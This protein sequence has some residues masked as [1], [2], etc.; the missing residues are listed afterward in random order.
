MPAEAHVGHS[1]TNV[2]SASTTCAAPAGAFGARDVA[3]DAA[4]PAHEVVVRL[5]RPSLEERGVTGKVYARGEAGTGEGVEAVVDRLGRD[6]AETVPHPSPDLVRAEVLMVAGR[7]RQDVEHGGPLRRRTQPRSAEQVEG[8]RHPSITTPQQ[9]TGNR[10][11]PPLAPS[12]R[13]LGRRGRAALP[14]RAQS[15]APG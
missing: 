4:A 13:G 10:S 7:R 9:G 3:D 1:P 14:G 5:R 11:G 6:H 8:A 15:H 12:A 2:T